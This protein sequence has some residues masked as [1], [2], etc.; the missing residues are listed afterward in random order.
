M[1]SWYNLLIEHNLLDFTEVEG[2]KPAEPAEKPATEAVKPAEAEESV[3][4][5]AKTE[6]P[7][8]KAG[9]PAKPVEEHAPGA[10]K[11]PEKIVGEAKPEKKTPKKKKQE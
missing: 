8:A 10:P 2:D 4:P 5:A 1:I 6:K 9:K 11:P 3:K 7:A